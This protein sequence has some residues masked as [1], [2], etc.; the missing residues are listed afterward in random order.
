MLLEVTALL[1]R[2]SLLPC[3]FII[4]SKTGKKKK[5]MALRSLTG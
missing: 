1:G 4:N 5:K 3:P 2:L